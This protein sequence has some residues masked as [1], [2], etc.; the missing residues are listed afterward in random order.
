MEEEEINETW[1]VLKEHPAY[2]INCSYP[3]QIRK[4]SNRKILG[5]SLRNDYIRVHLNNK[6]YYKHRLIALQWLPNPENLP[7][8]DHINHIK[9]D[10][11]ISNLRWCSHLQNMNNKCRTQIGR[12]VEYVVELPNNAVVVER[13]SRFDFE[14]LYFHGGLFYIDT[15]NGNYRIVPTYMNQGRRVVGLRDKFGMRRL[16]MYNKFLREYGLD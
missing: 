3:H 1:E 8:I 4:I 12:E 7:C 5:E 11:R 2:E 6:S 15:G 16:I 9:T 13:Y 14:G 10:N